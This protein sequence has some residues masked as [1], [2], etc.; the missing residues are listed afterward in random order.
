MVANS[1][2]DQPSDGTLRIAVEVAYATP[3]RQRI[4]KLHV[5]VGTTAGQAIEASGLRAQFPAI[6][7]CPEVGIFSR[8]VPLGEPLREGDRVEIY[9]PLL[10]DPKEARRERASG[11]KKSREPGPR[12]KSIRRHVR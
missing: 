1:R 8:K 4:V 12:K 6:E 2:V 5:P 9:R 10:A 11:E 3:Q 7:P